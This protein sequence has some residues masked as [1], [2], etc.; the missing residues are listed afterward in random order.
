[1]RGAFFMPVTRYMTSKVKKPRDFFHERCG[2]VYN[3]KGLDSYLFA[4]KTK[5]VI[6]VKIRKLREGD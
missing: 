1:M 6:I 5:S 2:F 4:N 3:I